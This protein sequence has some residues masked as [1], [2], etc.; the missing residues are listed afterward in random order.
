[1]LR[2]AT[3]NKTSLLFSSIIS[4]LG[5]LALFLLST[6]NKIGIVLLVV[7]YYSFIFTVLNIDQSLILYGLLLTIPFF[8][9]GIGFEAIYAVI[10]MVPFIVVKYHRQLLASY[11][12]LINK[13]DPIS[14]GLSLMG[15][16]LMVSLVN[17]IMRGTF[18]QNMAIQTGY[19]VV[20]LTIFL[21]FISLAN[22]RNMFEQI[23]LII[24]IPTV[25]FSV[26]I[27]IYAVGNG[28][29]ALFRVK[30]VS[31]LT[32]DINSNLPAMMLT[33]LTM[34]LLVDTKN[35]KDRM[36]STMHAIAI[37]ASVM[38]VVMTNSRGAWAGLLCAIC[39]IIIRSKKGKIILLTAIISLL[40]F[41]LIGDVILKRF[42]QTNLRDFAIIS[43]LWIWSI[44]L[45]Y[46]VTNPFL[47]L[48]PN[49]F[50]LEKFK[51]GFPPFLDPNRSFS[52]HNMYLEF[53]TDFSVLFLI[54]FLMIAGY[55]FWKIDFKYRSL[56]DQDQKQYL[57]A[58][59]AA[60]ITVLVHGLFDCGIA[61]IA[62]ASVMTIIFGLAVV[63]TRKP[64]D[65]Q[66]E[67]GSVDHL[68]QKSNR[69][70]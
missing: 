13:V 66:Q 43:R 6:D 21:L 15:F 64:N 65:N 32:I 70:V 19:L 18:D 39:Y 46:I 17:A 67:L 36:Q 56:S 10:L 52:A 60:I 2:H 29:E 31:I 50:C 24:R 12:S 4:L 69:P 3:S 20:E 55:V 34:L 51:W 28:F 54:G 49:G 5:I 14:I 8:G 23:L 9:M 59:N 47:G 62:I 30:H 38:A 53:A 40:L 11:K 61:N 57:L 48:G 27:I 68:M 58:I 44:A 1:M 42:N 45:A 63:I 7:V 16:G 22:K 33:P 37:I 35:I 26:A 41:V 25:I